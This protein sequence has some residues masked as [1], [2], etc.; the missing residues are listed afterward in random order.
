MQPIEARSPGVLRLGRIERADLHPEVIQARPHHHC[1]ID[2]GCN[3]DEDRDAGHDRLT[4]ETAGPLE[5]QEDREDEQKRQD[6]LD[7]L[8]APQD[9]S[10]NVSRQITRSDPPGKWRYL[11]VSKWPDGPARVIGIASFSSGEAAKVGSI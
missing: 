11:I 7:R 6:V 8:E 5:L 10:E 4:R 2:V 9:L 1:Q 3:R